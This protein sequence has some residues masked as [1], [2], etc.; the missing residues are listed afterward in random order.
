MDTGENDELSDYDDEDYLGDEQQEG[1]DDENGA[2]DEDIE[3]D[4]R[5]QKKLEDLLT[6]RQKAFDDQYKGLQRNVS[7]KDREILELKKALAM[8]SAYSKSGIEDA[9]EAF[10]WM[11][12]TV[13]AALPDDA[14]KQAELAFK[15]RKAN[16]AM[17]RLASAQ[18]APQAQARGNDSDDEDVP[19]WVRE[20]IQKFVNVA[21]KSATRA[22]LDP[23]D[24]S[25]DYGNDNDG[26]VE[27][28]EAFEESLEKAVAAKKDSRTERVRQKQE[29]VATRTS[30]GGSSPGANV[31]SRDPL[32][33]G[34]SQRLRDIRA[35]KYG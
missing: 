20:R 4:P 25:L 9:D 31:S 29:P 6:S 33:S 2:D 1:D 35:G 3:I 17:R 7:A 13:L 11:A 24:K 19:D 5:V 16:L 23:D 12:E 32:R 28:L 14:R 15:E 30:G 21:R 10:Q 8:N 18:Q 34:S 26:L 22:G 27:R